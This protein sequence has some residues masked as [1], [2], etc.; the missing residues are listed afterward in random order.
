VKACAFIEGH[1]TKEVLER[2]DSEKQITCL[3]KA[4]QNNRLAI[5]KALCDKSKLE[6]ADLN[7]ACEEEGK[8]ALIYAAI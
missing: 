3:A 8:T 1:A 4:C 5:V 7:V 2:V 6:G